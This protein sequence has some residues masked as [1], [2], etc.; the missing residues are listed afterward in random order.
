MINQGSGRNRDLILT[1]IR[2]KQILIQSVLK[3]A[4]SQTYIHLQASKHIMLKQQIL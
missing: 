2:F 4:E 1:W 3:S